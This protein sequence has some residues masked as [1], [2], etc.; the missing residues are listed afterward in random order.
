MNEAEFERLLEDVSI[1]MASVA[2]QESTAPARPTAPN[3]ARQPPK[4]ANDNDFND[5]DVSDDDV[6]ERGFDFSA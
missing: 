2:E 4:A 1:V 6:T 3:T 5:N